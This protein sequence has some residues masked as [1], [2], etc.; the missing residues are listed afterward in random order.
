MTVP[1]RPVVGRQLNA[2]DV[3]LP[4]CMCV[5]PPQSPRLWLQPGDAG[6]SVPAG[7]PVSSVGTTRKPVV[8]GAAHSGEVHTS[9]T[10]VAAV[11]TDDES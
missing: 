3:T 1:R 11:C 9:V 2:H 10:L 8:A 6:D 5:R 7:A 4:G